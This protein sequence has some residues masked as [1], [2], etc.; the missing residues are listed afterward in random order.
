MMNVKSSKCS[1]CPRAIFDDDWLA[2]QGAELVGDDAA[3]RV[4]SRCPDRTR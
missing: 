4:S 1:I 3:N 2:E